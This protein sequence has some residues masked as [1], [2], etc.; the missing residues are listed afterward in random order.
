MPGIKIT[1][2]DRKRIDAKFICTSCKLVLYK[3]MQTM[4]GHLMCQSCIETLLGSS[5]PKC[6]EDGEEL[7]KEKV[8]PDVFTKRELS[9]LHLHCAN[10]GCSWQSTYDKLEGHSQVCEHAL[11]KCMHPQCHMKFK[12][13]QLGEHYNSECEYRNVKCDHCGKDVVH[14][15][16]KEHLG[17]RCENAPVACKYCKKHVLRKDIEKHESESCEAVPATCG[18]HAVGCSSKTPLKR[19]ELRKHL[20]KELVGHITLLLCFVLFLA[21][22]FNECDSRLEYTGMLQKA[23]RG[24]IADVRSGLAEKCGMLVGKL[25]SL[26]RRI[27]TLE[28]SGGGD[29]RLRNEVN[30]M[31]IR[32]RDLTSECTNIRERNTRLEQQLRDRMSIMIPRQCREDVTLQRDMPWQQ[33]ID[34]Y[35]GILLWKIESYQRKRQDAIKGVK[36]FLYSPPFY[37]DQFGYKMCAKI[38]MNGDGSRRGS[39]LSLFFVLMRGDYDTL[40]TWPFQKKITMMLLDQGNGDHMIYTFHSDPQSSSFQRPK[41]DTNIASGSPLFIPLDSLNNRQYI[42]DDVMFIKVIVD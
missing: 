40:K 26:E 23:V 7:S 20:E 2:E 16:L 27:E 25:T 42:K 5:D 39:H 22:K 6:P 17:T 21:S 8:F 13:S 29:A 35:N 24:D 37:S 38:Y 3:P 1:D 28:S 18:F 34:S 11:I 4:C 30:E 31:S 36:T 32:L 14:A 41:S 15:L 12:S 33:A 9:G 10:S 19:K